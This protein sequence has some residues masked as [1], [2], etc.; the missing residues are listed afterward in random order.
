MPA[1]TPANLTDWREVTRLALE[2]VK[3]PSS[4]LA[5]AVN[6]WAWPE[7]REATALATLI[8]LLS[9]DEAAKWPRP[10]D[11]RQPDRLDNGDAGILNA[12]L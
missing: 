1:P 4:H 2:L 9:S 8:D 6:G 12:L 10:W 5:A 11:N 3:D 7:S